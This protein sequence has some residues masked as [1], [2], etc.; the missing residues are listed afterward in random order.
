QYRQVS[1]QPL[2]LR[3]LPRVLRPQPRVLLAQLAGHPRQ[4]PVRL[5][6]GGQH[7]PQRCLSILRI[8]DNAS[9]SHHAAQQTPSAAA[10]HASRPRVSQP[11]ALADA[12]A[13][14]HDFRILTMNAYDLAFELYGPRGACTEWR[15]R[16]YRFI[17]EDNR[18][19][20]DI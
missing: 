1:A 16:L 17:T 19:L 10:N 5:Q 4:L 18:S 6:R 14:S 13:P 8:R 3:R 12:N 15:I 2:Q 20:R 7:V 9:R 11:A